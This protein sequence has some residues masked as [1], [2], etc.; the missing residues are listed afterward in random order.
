MGSAVSGSAIEMA[1]V[2]PAVA[3]A[4]ADAIASGDG[5]AVLRQLSRCS[6]VKERLELLT[7]TLLASSGSTA[8]HVAAANLDGPSGLALAE[9]IRGSLKAAAHE[10]GGVAEAAWTA[11]LEAR[12]SNGATPLLV[13]VSRLR[14]NMLQW[15]LDSGADAWARD[16]EGSDAL[17]MLAHGSCEVPP[18]DLDRG[19]KPEI[20]AR[21]VQARLLRH[22]ES[23]S[24]TFASRGW[25]GQTPRDVPIE[26]HGDVPAGSFASILAC[27]SGGSRGH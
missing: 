19:A 21:D 22:R 2:D 27:C 26:E 25:S 6:D 23:H 3:L 9:A 18:E 11:A 13:A 16:S 5:D 4:F 8:L 17:D 1:D 14:V 15:L 12:D 24:A 10:L 20:I 7:K